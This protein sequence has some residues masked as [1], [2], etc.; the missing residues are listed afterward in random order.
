VFEKHIIW[1]GSYLFWHKINI[2]FKF[3]L[4][5]VINILQKIDYY[6][7]FDYEIQWR[8]KLNWNVCEEEHVDLKIQLFLT[9]KKKK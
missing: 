8:K 6:P 3:T 5:M 4:D 2:I 7:N 1:P 9:R